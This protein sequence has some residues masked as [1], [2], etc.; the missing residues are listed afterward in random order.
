MNP[1]HG[2]TKSTEIIS[3]VVH[4]RKKSTEI[5]GSV[6]HGATGP[7]EIIVFVD[8][9]VPHNRSNGTR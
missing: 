4:G 5:I 2:T 7:T 6:V 8:F 1:L 3:F 9:V